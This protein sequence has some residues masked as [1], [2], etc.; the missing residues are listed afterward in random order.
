[1]LRKKKYWKNLT[2]ARVAR[3]YLRPV[4]CYV[5]RPLGSS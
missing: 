2:L 5:E 4:I 3:G 1:M